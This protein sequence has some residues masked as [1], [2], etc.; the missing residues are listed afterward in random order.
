MVY[1]LGHFLSMDDISQLSAGFSLRTP[2]FLL[3]LGLLVA[4]LISLLHLGRPAN[5]IHALNNLKTSWISRE[6]FTVTLFSIS[7][8]MLFIARWLGAGKPFLTA[9]FVFSAMAGLLLLLAMVRLYMIPAVST[10][11]TW[12]TPTNF[13]LTA[14]ISGIALTLLFVQVFNIEFIRAKPIILALMI[15]LLL[16]MAHSGFLHAHLNSMDLNE[17][18]LFIS[19]RIFTT[20]TIIRIAVISLAILGLVFIYTQEK[21]RYHSTLLILS[22]SL[23]FI[24]MIIGRFVFFA[25]HVRIGI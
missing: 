17:S 5:A 7:L 23:I 8:L 9:S 1:A 15:L 2:E 12:L 4:L 3:M 18:N 14:L 10:W 25:T 13:T 24:E 19:E 11:N 20:F 6:I 22:V 21:A 16:E